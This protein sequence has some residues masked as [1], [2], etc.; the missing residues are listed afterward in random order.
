[1]TDSA[2]WLAVTELG[3]TPRSGPFGCTIMKTQK[4]AVKVGRAWGQQCLTQ[5]SQVPI[6]LQH[7]IPV[8]VPLGRAQPCPLILGEGHLH[9]L[10]IQSLLRNRTVPQSQSTDPGFQ[11][12]AG[13][14][15]GSEGEQDGLV[16]EKEK[17]ITQQKSPGL[18]GESLVSGTWVS[19]CAVTVQRRKT[20]GSRS[21]PVRQQHRDVAKD[22]GP[23]AHLR[24]ISWAAL[25]LGKGRHLGSRRI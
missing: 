25:F 22:S 8:E 10:E 4:A 7:H 13:E 2:T 16:R 19:G 3:R 23:V 15:A 11:G 14:R 6:V 1:M 17:T 18:E 21:Y 20:R 24:L 12:A 9:V 5:R